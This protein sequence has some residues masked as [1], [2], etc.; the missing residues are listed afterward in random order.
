[1][2]EQMFDNDDAMLN[3]C[4][5]TRKVAYQVPEGYFEDLPGRIMG[6][7]PEQETTVRVLGRNIHEAFKYWVGAGIAAS[8][9]LG[10]IGVKRFTHNTKDKFM[11]AAEEQYAYDLMDYGMVDTDDVYSYLSGDYFKE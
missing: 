11:I 3:A 5:L 8:L 4:G 6:L 10:F 2:R 1:M 7:I 9:I